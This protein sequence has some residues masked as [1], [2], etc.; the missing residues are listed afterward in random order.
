MRITRDLLQKIA[1]ETVDRLVRSEA[2]LQSAYL[3][4][5]LLSA[6]PLLGGTTDIDLVLIHK[7]Q[8]PVA[9]Q[10]E[11]I[12]TEVS[13][14]IV[15]YL[16]E[17]LDQHR[18]L[19]QDPWRGYPL[20]HSNIIL[21]DTDHWLEFIQASVSADFHRPDNVLARAQVMLASA[22]Q[23]WF[24]LLDASANDHNLWLD[25]F[26]NVLSLS[27]NA[28]AGLIGPPLGNRRFLR[29][30]SDRVQA[31]GAPQLLAG[32][33]GLLGLPE[34]WQA[35]CAARADQLTDT[36]AQVDHHD[37]PPG[38]APC[39]HAYYQSAIQALIESGNAEQA[40]WPLLRTWLDARLAGVTS[41][42]EE[43]DWR[44]FL[45]SL[46]LDSDKAAEKATALDA[47]L[48]NLEV[49]IEAWAETYV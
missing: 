23:G 21:F 34:A 36:L 17:D 18:Q 35:E 13:L 12:T 14:D 19:R 33:Y 16:K 31:L 41:P 24:T 9:R 22:R 25:Q 10:T 30:L 43:S 46:Q 26:L 44:D 2:D 32:F 5:S 37:V 47:Y 15:H 1:Q 3:T 29:T 39:R 8:A 27:A 42:K 48:D 40:L 11:G 45:Q 7:Y 49:I 38:I 6:E 4:G 28:V 20:T